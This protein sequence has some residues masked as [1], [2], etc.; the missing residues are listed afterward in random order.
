MAKMSKQEALMAVIKRASD[1]IRLT[2]YSEYK[3]S[4]LRSLDDAID[5]IFSEDELT[6]EHINYSVNDAVELAEDEL[7]QDTPPEPYVCS[8]DWDCP[9][10]EFEYACDELEAFGRKIRARLLEVCNAYANL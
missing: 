3:D 9:T 10:L 8:E 2:N 4:I 5:D 1:E 7:A 6:A